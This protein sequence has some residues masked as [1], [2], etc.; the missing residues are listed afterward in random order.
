MRRQLISIAA[1]VAVGAAVVPSYAGTAH[2]TARSSGTPAAGLLVAGSRTAQMPI[3]LRAAAEPPMWSI[4]VTTRGTYAGYLLSTPAGEAVYGALWVKGISQDAHEA[5]P[6]AAPSSA[7]RPGR[8]VLTLITD[9]FTVIHIPLVH[10]ARM[11][12]LP[13]TPVR[14]YAARIRP[15]VL[16]ASAVG[17]P[18]AYGAAPVPAGHH[19]VGLLAL[20]SD[21]SATQLS[22]GDMC[23]TSTGSCQAGADGASFTWI[24]PGAGSAGSTEASITYPADFDAGT[25]AV[26]SEA[27][28]GLAAQHE[29]FALILG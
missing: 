4:D 5:L 15:D 6:L 8:Y 9:G 20:H 21:G 14:A 16:P 17:S 23:F 25:Q 11:I 19:A 12:A 13:T 18:V 3:T 26:V 27:D 28:A 1:M 2:G 10:G 22:H 29:A 7:I 24:T